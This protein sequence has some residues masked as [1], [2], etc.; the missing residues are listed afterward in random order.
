MAVCIDMHFSSPQNNFDYSECLFTT[1]QFNDFKMPLHLLLLWWTSLSNVASLLVL[2][3]ETGEYDFITTDRN[4]G[5][6]YNLY[7]G[8]P[9]VQ[10]HQYPPVQQ[11]CDLRVLHLQEVP[12]Q[13]C[14]VHLPIGAQHE[15][16]L[17]SRIRWLG[18]KMGQ[19]SN[20]GVL[21][22]QSAASSSSV[23]I[24][25]IVTVPCWPANENKWIKRWLTNWQ[26]LESFL[27]M[28]SS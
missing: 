24:V 3:N 20:H 9:G 19:D 14:D 15:A 16:S 18:Y 13:L 11:L 6:N 22:L 1:S 25:L 4:E 23:F 2:S 12:N 26:Q 8:H 27:A 5:K 7:G 17:T 28:L 21:V 10:S